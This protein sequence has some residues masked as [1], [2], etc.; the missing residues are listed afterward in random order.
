[1]Y[2]EKL[3]AK[4]GYPHFSGFFFFFEIDLFIFERWIVT[5]KGRNRDASLPK[6]TS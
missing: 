1:M 3:K 6:F 5:G 2:K 4:V